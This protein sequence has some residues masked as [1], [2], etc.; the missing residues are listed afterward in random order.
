M[1]S[2]SRSKPANSKKRNRDS[3]TDDYS[4]ETKVDTPKK[5]L[6]VFEF[7]EYDGF[8]DT[9]FKKLVVTNAAAPKWKL[10]KHANNNQNDSQNKPTPKNE[11][12]NK[13]ANKHESLNKHTNNQNE[14]RNKAA[15]KK[16]FD[17]DDDEDDDDDDDDGFDIPLSTFTQNYRASSNKRN[18]LQGSSNGVLKVKENETNKVDDEPEPTTPDTEKLTKDG[19]PEPTTPDTEKLTKD[20]EDVKNDKQ[21]TPSYKIYKRTKKSAVSNKSKEKSAVSNKSKEKSNS[22]IRK[23]LKKPTQKVTPVSVNKVKASNDKND[24]VS[25]KQILRDKI[26]SMLLDAGWT[27]D[28]RPRKN[29][30][31]KDAVYIT[32]TG[33][34]YWSIVKAYDAFQK[35]EQ[36]NSKDDAEFTPLPDEV[37][38][39]LTRQTQKKMERETNNK[40]KNEGEE[41]DYTDE[42]NG[43]KSRKLGRCTLLV[44]RSDKGV[45][46]ANGFELYSGKRSILSW[47]IDSGVVDVSE[48]VEYMNP[49]K[50]RTMQKGSITKD[51]IHCDCCS[52]IVTF[53]KFEEHSG[54]KLGDPFPNIFLKSGKSL[55]QCQIDAWDKL[56]ELE[57][58]G[59]YT[60]DVDGDDPNDDTC[61][62]CGDGGD[63]IC[64]DGCPSTFHQSCLDIEMLPEGDW[65]CP[66]CPCKYCETVGGK[67]EES[68]LTCGLC[69]KKYHESCRPEIDVKPIEKS[70]LNLSFCGRKCHELYSQLQKEVGVKHELDSGFSWSLVHR[71][72][73]LTDASSVQLSRGVEC[74]SML[75]VAMSVMDECF[76]PV[77]DRKSKTNLIRNVVFNCG[78]NLSRLN[79]SGFFTAILERGDE[80]VCA[81]SI[82]IHGTQLAE[83]PFIG[84]RHVHRRQGMCSRLLSAIELALSSLHVEKLIIPAVAEHMSTWTDVFGFRP[85]E[86]SHKQE[87]RSLNM[88]VFPGTD[89]LQKPLV[90]QDTLP[91]GNNGVL[92]DNVE[93][94]EL[95]SSNVKDSSDKTATADGSQEPGDH[96]CSVDANTETLPSDSPVKDEMH[97]PVVAPNS[98]EMVSSIKIADDADSRTTQVLDVASRDTVSSDTPCEPKVLV[99]VDPHVESNVEETATAKATDVSDVPSSNFISSA[100]PCESKPQIPVNEPVSTNLHSDTNVGELAMQNG[101]E[102]NVKT[103]PM[104]EKLDMQNGFDNTTDNISLE[105]QSPPKVAS[106]NNVSSDAPCEQES[107]S[108]VS[109]TPVTVEESSADVILE[110]GIHAVEDNVKLSEGKKGLYESEI[111]AQ[112]RV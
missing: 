41:D 69:Q 111:I 112:E 2:K 92:V 5:G 87:M 33:T 35:M 97:V 89:M 110:T 81:A 4:S 18:G 34:G 107:P 14:S 62:L 83:M 99:S 36:D 44:R 90:K 65:H 7:D 25:E 49:R 57:K 96:G 45:N 52:K 10:T 29:R 64:C 54:S 38:G 60:I 72:D 59:F 80:V 95:I 68:L 30:A 40:R 6:D 42:K 9:R 109:H 91:E 98:S 12:R 75:A 85:L 53:S 3:S 8:D 22:S 11:S 73:L 56:G 46:S 48:H 20:G 19:E 71:S 27:I 37:L 103:M 93:K 26:K 108:L 17:S 21:E 1:K 50:T 32:P 66:N 106:N 51:G 77:T 55:M 67:T 70:C 58:N 104:V 74:N 28:Y 39:K 102:T 79:Y 86:E 16:L 43:R 94:S 84:T 23:V 88:L 78:S 47:L 15:T 101:N 61:G 31:Y 63:L 105:A 82:R 13:A 100:T 24:V 76:L